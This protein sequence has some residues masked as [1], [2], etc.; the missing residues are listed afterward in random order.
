[1]HG[2]PD[3]IRQDARIFA[4]SSGKA[5]AAGRPALG[6][7]A[8]SAHSQGRVEARRLRRG[9]GPNESDSGCTGGRQ[10]S[11][12][13]QEGVRKEGDGGREEGDR[14]R[15]EGSGGEEERGDGEEEGDGLI[16]RH[17]LSSYRSRGALRSPARRERRPGVRTARRRS[18]YRGCMPVRLVQVG[19]RVCAANRRFPARITRLDAGIRSAGRGSGFSPGNLNHPDKHAGLYWRRG[20]PRGLL[21]NVS[22]GRRADRASH[23]PLKRLPKAVRPGARKSMYSDASRFGTKV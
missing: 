16:T 3:P 13:D 2:N 14:S 9:R 6:G 17:R 11:S 18:R 10:E 4:A 5:N 23:G 20:Q 15:E 19:V 8:D 22:W 1:M 12:G 21:R 7:P